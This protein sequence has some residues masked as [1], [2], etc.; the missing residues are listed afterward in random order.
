MD[1]ASP[2]HHTIDYVEFTVRDMAEAQRF[3]A[4]AFGWS[5]NDYGPAYAGIRRGDGEAGGFS[6]GSS[7]TSG[8]PL[9][10]A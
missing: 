3:H 1:A 9:V 6:V 4:A 10:I 2:A 7:V 5:F 8:G